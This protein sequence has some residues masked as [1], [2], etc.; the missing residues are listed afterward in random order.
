MSDTTTTTTPAPAP[1]GSAE[2]TACRRYCGYPAYGSGQTGF[3]SWRFFGAYG[4][5]EFR[6]ANL[7]PDELGVV[8]SFIAQLAV[9][10]AAI[11]AA[12]AN[13]DTEAA[14]VWKH[15]VAEIRDRTA[16]YTQWRL[17]LVAFLGLPPGPGLETSSFIRV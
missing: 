10:E 4:T 2:L 15:N 7:A 9:L 17:Q 8:R 14:A 3:Q 5:L 1:L 16:L 11:P 6:L 13:L 12:A